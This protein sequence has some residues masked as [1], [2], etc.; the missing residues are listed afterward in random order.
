MTTDPLFD[1]PY[2]EQESTG[3]IGLFFL[4]LIKI[5]VLAGVTIVF[6]RYFLFKPFLVK[7]KSMEP[8]FYESEYLIINELS[9]RFIEPERGEVIV[10][11]APNVQEKDYYL[12]RI[13]GLP[14]ERVRIED[15]KV[16]VYNAENPEG[17]VVEEEYLIEET[18]GSIQYSLGE[19]EYFVMGD[20][21]DESFDSRKFGPIH[22]DTIVGKTWIR[23]W[24]FTRVT[25]F[26]SPTYNL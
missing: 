18:Y 5:A 14:G 24:P 17:V 2:K 4:E 11:E 19:E 23:G 6:I 22:R 3:S 9:Y 16:I 20:N 12:K 25:I 10:F 26:D 21:R 7:G 8:T 13:I 15:Q 1:E